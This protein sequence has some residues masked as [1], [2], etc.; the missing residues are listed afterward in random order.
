MK[1]ENRFIIQNAGWAALHPLEASAARKALR[2]Y[3]KEHPTCEITGTS[4]EVQ[5]HHIIPIWA[6]PSKAADK[7]N[8]IALSAS[9]HIHHLFGH[10]GNF[11]T[12]YVANIKE[13]AY[14]IREVKNQM[15]I[16]E[17]QFETLNKQ[18]LLSKLLK[19]LKFRKN[20]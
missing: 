4:K 9:C 18:T 13:I 10:A 17:R 14:T 1:D 19:W 11:R 7:T 5:I 3:R 15:I 16:V 6:D 2:E 12:K 8:L 20:I